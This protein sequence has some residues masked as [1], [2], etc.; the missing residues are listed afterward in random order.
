MWIVI[1]LIGGSSAKIPMVGLP[2]NPSSLGAS[3]AQAGQAV[4]QLLIPGIN[5]IIAPQTAMGPGGSMYDRKTQGPMIWIRLRKAQPIVVDREF[6]NISNVPGLEVEKLVNPPKKPTMTVNEKKR[7]EIPIQK[8][9]TSPLSFIQSQH[10]VDPQMIQNGLYLSQPL[11]QPAQESIN[12]AAVEDVR[13]IQ[14]AADHYRKK[15]EIK[16]LENRF[17][18]VLN[19][20]INR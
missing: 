13:S 9:L 8:M 6:Y 1:L 4:A 2:T 19:Q 17:H 18:D 20:L 10:K 15:K 5:S 3:G 11:R 12:I 16:R 7:T 14:A